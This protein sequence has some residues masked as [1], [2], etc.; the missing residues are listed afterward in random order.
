M[1]V[2]GLVTKVPVKQ[3]ELRH[4][5]AAAVLAQALEVGIGPHRSLAV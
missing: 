4:G 3:E 1:P 5:L 2:T